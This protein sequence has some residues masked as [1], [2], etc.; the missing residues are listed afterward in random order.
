MADSSFDTRRLDGLRRQLASVKRWLVLL[1]LL[2]VLTVAALG[3]IAWR[4][5]TFTQR[6]ETK[7]T[8]LQQTANQKLDLRRQFC[9]KPYKNTLVSQLCE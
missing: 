3:Y 4:A 6:A 8:T 1:S 9:Q 7:I 5:V 2:W